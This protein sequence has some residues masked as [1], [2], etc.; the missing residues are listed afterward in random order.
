MLGLTGSTLAIDGSDL[1]SRIIRVNHAGEHGAVNIY[2]GQRILAALTARSILP[3]LAHFQ[4]HEQEH[5]ATFA[6]ELHRRGARRCR[7][8][9]LCG[10]GG[11]VLG[12]ITGALGRS[13]IAATTVA[14]ENVVLRHLQEQLAEL[15][16]SDPAACAA[17]ESIVREEQE[18]HDRSQAQ[19]VAGSFWS[20]V[21][22]PVVRSST[23]AVI[24]MGM[25][26]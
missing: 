12:L 2:R 24:W 5:R 4:T 13:A 26:L 11:L 1:G 8:Y 3:E 22:T 25:R 14:V 15:S 18:H 23:E 9:W 21:L 17:I 20:R 7:S 10:L 6:A 19:V 16:G